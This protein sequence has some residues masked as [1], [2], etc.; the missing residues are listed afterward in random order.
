M[1]IVYQ[2][3]GERFDFESINK[4]YREDVCVYLKD[5]KYTY[6]KCCQT[7]PHF[8]KT[9]NGYKC[10]DCGKIFLRKSLDYNGKTIPFSQWGNQKR[11]RGRKA[12]Y[13]KCKNGSIFSTLETGKVNFMYID[14]KNE[15]VDKTSIKVKKTTLEHKLNF[16]NTFLT[17]TENGVINV[18]NMKT[19]E[20]I[21]QLKSGKKYYVHKMKIF[22][23]GKKGEWIYIDTEKIINF[24]GDF[25]QKQQVIYF[26]SILD[27]EILAIKSV[28]CNVEYN[29]FLIHVCYVS[30]ETEN[31]KYIERA[32]II[33]TYQHN[34][35]DIKILRYGVENEL[36]YNFESNLY[37][38]VKHNEMIKMDDRCNVEKICELPVIRSYLD[39]RKVFWLEEFIGFPEKLYFLKDNVIVLRYCWEIVIFDVKK[40]KIITS[41]ESNLI[42]S[43]FIISEQTI[44]F[45]AG[46]NT[47][48]VQ[49]DLD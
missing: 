22:P 48:I 27:N 34:K 23:L 49:L 25:D 35:F 9:K 40:Q 39:G 3:E 29:Y 37:Y 26:E 15:L 30:G 36:T 5:K 4:G 7:N 41:I 10:M 43:F 1:K 45:S 31:N 17:I 13:I 11:I 20:T 18:Y 19:G 8:E 6:F 32:T 42:Q 44:C 33:L 24:S 46:L 14:N 16:N 47:Y 38:G 12:D 21:S 28:D 2:N